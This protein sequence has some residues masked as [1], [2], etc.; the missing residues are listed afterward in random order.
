MDS[1]G[2]PLQ[3]V[4][5]THVSTTFMTSE[6][7]RVYGASLLGTATPISSWLVESGEPLMRFLVAG[8]QLAVALLTALYIYQKWKDARGRSR[9]SRKQR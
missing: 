3:A 7:I 8:G 1:G 2:L 4:N 6:N 5:E 9:N